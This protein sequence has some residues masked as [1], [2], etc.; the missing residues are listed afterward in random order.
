MIRRAVIVPRRTEEAKAYR[1]IHGDRGGCKFQDK[2]YQPSV[3]PW[4]NTLTQVVKDNL[5]CH[6]YE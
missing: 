6:I 3:W 5:L 4:S 2:Y 1:R